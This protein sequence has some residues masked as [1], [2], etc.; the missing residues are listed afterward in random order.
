MKSLMLLSSVVALLAVA[1]VLLFLLSPWPSA[2]LLRIYMDKGGNSTAAALEAR[3]PK[4]VSAQ[5][6]LQYEAGRPEALDVFYPS[7]VE[8]TDRALPTVVWIHGGGWLAGSKGQISGY[9]K[10]LAA[11]GYTT[12]GV[13]Y[14]LAPA[15]VYPAPLLRVNAALG[16]IQAHASRLHVDASKLFLAGDSVGAQIAAQFAAVISDPSYARAVGIV[17][18]IEPR[19]LLGVVLH[20]GFYDGLEL[21]YSWTTFPHL[22][23]PALRTQLWSYLGTLGFMKDPRLDQ[24]S[25][26]HHVTASF[27]P[28]FVSVGNAD[29][30]EPQ[31]RKL[32]DRLASLGVAT[33]TLFFPKDGQLHL[34]HQYQF[35][36][37]NEAGRLALERSVQFLAKRAQESR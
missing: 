37:D 1:I 22:V 28:A 3:A 33:E 36:L 11:K 27:P 31:S 26:L 19:K 24:I 20:C 34:Y 21:N 2:L 29:W 35:N 8:G 14:P 9:L 7:E 4:N 23:G 12:I 6:D 15:N 5:R 18:S 10:I 30:L 17:P 32:A 25:V 16:Y 13:D